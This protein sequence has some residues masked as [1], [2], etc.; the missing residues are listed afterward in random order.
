MPTWTNIAVYD[1]VQIR[2]CPVEQVDDGGVDVP[3]LVS[4]R[5]AEPH[6]GL[7]RMSAE[8]GA[9][10]AIRPHEAVPGRGRGPSRAEPLREDGERAGRDVTVVGRGHPV[11]DR[12]DRGGRQSMR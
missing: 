10:P 11:L 2:A 6:R 5:R 8:P 1:G 7:G 3:P 12:P 4:A 9:S